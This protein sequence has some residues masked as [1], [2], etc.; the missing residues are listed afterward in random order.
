MQGWVRIAANMSLGAYEVF[1]AAGENLPEPTWPEVDFQTL[2][3]TAFKGHF[4]QSF[5]HPVL[6]RLRGEV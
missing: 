6:R 3:R 2:L 1:V 5:D 4:I